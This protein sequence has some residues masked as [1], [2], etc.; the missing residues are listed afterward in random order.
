MKVTQLVINDFKILDN[1]VNIDEGIY[2]R[3]LKGTIEAITNKFCKRSFLYCLLKIDDIIIGYLCCIPLSKEFCK[4]IE[5]SNDIKKD[6]IYDK[7][8]DNI[9]LVSIGILEEFKESEGIDML[10]EGWVDRL[11]TEIILILSDHNNIN[12]I[13]TFSVSKEGEKLL[14]QLG[15]KD[16]LT[17]A[18]GYK[19]YSMDINTMCKWLKLN[20]TI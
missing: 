9:R 18:N 16:T 3:Y 6:E 15:F 12:D 17:H 2:P 10:V 19:L 7:F 20:K 14:Q 5:H 11:R 13:L 4:G 8:S 1:I